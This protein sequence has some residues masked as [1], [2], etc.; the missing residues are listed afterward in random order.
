MSSSGASVDE[1]LRVYDADK[2]SPWRVRL[3][4]SW[5]VTFGS[6]NDQASSI[7]AR[8]ASADGE[9]TG[10]LMIGVVSRELLK[11]P[12][13]V[14]ALF[15]DALTE[16]GLT[17]EASDFV[18]EE[19]PKRFEQAWILTTTAARSQSL[20][21]A[22]RCRVLRHPRAWAVLGVLAPRREDEPEAHDEAVSTFDR[23]TTTLSVRG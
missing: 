16:V 15:L 13:E 22:V 11:R 14:A 3:P 18:A 21:G 9:V 23:A 5:A 2:P 4:A 1:D 7:E 8:R 19:P 6:S 10:K 20:S 12:R 17:L